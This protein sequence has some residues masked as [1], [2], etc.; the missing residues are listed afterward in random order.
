MARRGWKWRDLADL[1]RDGLGRFTS[2]PTGKLDLREYPKSD[3]KP[4]YIMLPPGH[5]ERAPERL[6]LIEEKTPREHKRDFAGAVKKSRKRKVPKVRVPKRG[7]PKLI[8]RFTSRA[9]DTVGAALEKSDALA[10]I[11]TL[12][13]GTLIR[14][15]VRGTTADGIKLKARER[16]REYEVKSTSKHGKAGQLLHHLF[17]VLGKEFFDARGRGYDM[18]DPN[19]KITWTIHIVPS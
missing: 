7:K 8:G 6:E 18:I 15:T 19:D 17:G 4:D 5:G 3:D 16:V 11:Q 9:V 2:K 14:I 1:W 13:A 10:I 12:P